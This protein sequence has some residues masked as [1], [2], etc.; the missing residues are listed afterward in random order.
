MHKLTMI[1]SIVYGV[2]ESALL[3]GATV[4]PF[5][6][7]FYIGV[8][9]GFGAT[10]WDGLVPL[11]EKQN[12]ALSISAP[13]KVYEGGGVYGAFAGYEFTPYFAIETS[14]RHYPSA[15]IIFDQ[16]SLF[17]F[18][19]E[20]RLSFDSRTY[21]VN[22]MAKVML[23]LPN[24]TARL[25]SSFGVAGVHRSDELIQQWQPSPTFGAGFNTYIS[26]HLMAEF[27]FNYTAGYGE[28][29]LNPAY[30]YIPFLYSVTLGLAY[31]I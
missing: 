18:D 14:Y 31:R 19:H 7:A 3:Q 20:D 5:Q 29:E 2:L 13:V 6:K 17:A 11:Q 9:G 10:T 26:Q 1:L 23:I 12:I 15:K 27:G 30:S 25:F 24:T 21:T 4:P 22:L 8:N 28:S 16:F